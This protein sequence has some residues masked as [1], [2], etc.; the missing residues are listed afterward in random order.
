MTSKLKILKR[1]QRVLELRCKGL[2]IPAI[3]KALKEQ[4]KLKVGERTIW[5][6]LHSKTAEDFVEELKRQ[7][8]ADIA[9]CG[10]DYK[11]RLQYRADMLDKLLPKRTELHAEGQL[12]IKMWQPDARPNQEKTNPEQTPPPQDG[13]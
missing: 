6:D 1:Q 8:L 4:D 9:Q 10:K 5:K 12:V 7:Q 3:A 11:T 2:T 13:S